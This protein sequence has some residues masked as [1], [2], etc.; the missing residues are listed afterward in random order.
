[1]S[2]QNSVPVYGWFD[3]VPD[4]LKTRNQLKEMGLRPT[5]QI[6][7]K[8]VWKRRGGKGVAYLYDINEVAAK[9]E[10]TEAQLM[11]LEKARM[12]RSTCPYCGHILYFVLPK[13]WTQ[14]DCENCSHERYL[15]DEK[16]AIEMAKQAVSD[17]LGCIL[18]T[19]TTDLNGYVLQIAVVD[20]AGRVLLDSLVNPLAEISPEAQRVHG[21]NA[22]ML[23]GAPSFAELLPQLRAVLAGRTVWVYNLAFEQKIFGNEQHRNEPESKLRGFQWLGAAEAQCA[24]DLY[25]SFIGE[26]HIIYDRD[27]SFTKTYRYQPLPYGDHSA[28]GD[29]LATLKVLQEVSSAIQ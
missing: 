16:Q 19:E 12:A 7:A 25:S 15:A 13:S 5:G 6:K 9:K 29:C 22:Q 14:S 4:G 10:A 8:V 21:I 11:A 1:M 17:P 27:G 23:Q 24:M 18:D 20:M 3:E 28:V 26:L 2:D